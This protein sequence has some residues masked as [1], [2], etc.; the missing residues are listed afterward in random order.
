M[1]ARRP[2][3]SEGGR[4]PAV[5]VQQMLAFG[6]HY[7]AF[8]AR[9]PPLT[10]CQRPKGCFQRPPLEKERPLSAVEAQPLAVLGIPVQRH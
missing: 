1:F 7:Y 10:V 9:P 3:N 4:S 2:Q 8:A 5:I 6:L